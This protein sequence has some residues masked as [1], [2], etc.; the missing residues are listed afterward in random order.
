MSFQKITILGRVGNSAEL[1]FTPSG[2]AV[3]G[4]SLASSETWKDGNGTKQERTTWHR[5]TLWGKTAEALAEH[6]TKGKLLLIEGTVT[7]RAY[8]DKNSEPQASLEVK[9]DQLRFAGGKN[10]G[11]NSNGSGSSGDSNGYSG[12]TAPEGEDIPF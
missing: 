4:F 12:T 10:D 1:R 6:V 5:C 2:V 7:A 8:M 9:V 3:A 11:D